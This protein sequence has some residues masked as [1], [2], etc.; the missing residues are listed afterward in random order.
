[1][2]L[3]LDSRRM[4]HKYGKKR[5]RRIAICGGAAWLF[6]LLLVNFEVVVHTAVIHIAPSGIAP[7]VSWAAM[8][9]YAIGCLLVLYGAW[10]MYRDE[11]YHAYIDDADHYRRNGW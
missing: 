5:G 11:V 3:L 8:V 4:A 9:I 1:M 2:L 6:A 7:I 10:L